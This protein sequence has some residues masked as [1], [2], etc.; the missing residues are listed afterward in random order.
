MVLIGFQWGKSFHWLA[1]RYD[2]TRVYPGL[3][4]GKTPAREGKGGETLAL[5][6]V[7]CPGL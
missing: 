6:G 1:A 5:L 7:S 4:G 2:V 3:G